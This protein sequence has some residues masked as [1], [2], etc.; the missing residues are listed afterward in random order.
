M[1][2][3]EKNNYPSFVFDQV[4][5]IDVFGA[6]EVDRRGGK[7]CFVLGFFLVVFLLDLGIR[8]SATS[9]KDWKTLSS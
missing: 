1:L 8:K 7:S 2:V 5:P 3:L 6:F 9:H 4:E